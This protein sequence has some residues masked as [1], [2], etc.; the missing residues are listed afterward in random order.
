MTGVRLCLMLDRNS[1][2]D[3]GSWYLLAA[4]PVMGLR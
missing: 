3:H 1:G 4:L 2:Q